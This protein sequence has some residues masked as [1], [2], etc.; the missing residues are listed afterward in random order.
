MNDLLLLLLGVRLRQGL[1]TY[2][3]G[4]NR[5]FD[6]CAYLGRNRHNLLRSKC[7][8][9]RLHSF[10]EYVVN[11]RRTLDGCR[12]PV[13]DLL[14][15]FGGEVALVRGEV[16]IFGNGGVRMDRRRWFVDRSRGGWC[17]VLRR[18]LL[19][20]GQGFWGRR[21]SRLLSHISRRRP[22]DLRRLSRLPGD[23]HSIHNLSFSKLEDFSFQLLD[24]GAG[25]ILDK[26]RGN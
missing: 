9:L 8:T 5:L 13:C 10:V 23:L 18:G 3:F 12:V 26:R 14:V 16:S 20:F 7:D 6:F 2:A 22:I 11:D 21:I 24:A 17:L 15:W 4:G 19:G 25:F 1:I